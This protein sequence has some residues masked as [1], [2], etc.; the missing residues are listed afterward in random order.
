ME[1]W[2]SFSDVV[3][4]WFYIGCCGPYGWPYPVLF[5]GGYEVVFHVL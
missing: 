2:F 1:Y 4:G 5:Y 3:F